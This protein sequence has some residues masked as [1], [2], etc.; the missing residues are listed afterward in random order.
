MIVLDTSAAI[1]YFLNTPKGQLVAPHLEGQEIYAPQ[2]LVLEVLQVLRKAERAGLVSEQKAAETLQNFLDTSIQLIDLS[3]L[4]EPVW[5]Y[6]H[7]MSAYD[8]AYVAL[9]AS[10]DC[11]LLTFDERLARAAPNALVPSGF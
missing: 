6:R 5:Q 2:H 3:W 7:R 10:L 4:V 1:E 9:A 8:A 11:P